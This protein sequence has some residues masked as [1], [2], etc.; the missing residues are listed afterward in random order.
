MPDLDLEH[1][2]LT[3]MT[4]QIAE[5][6]DKEIVN[7]LI[8]LQLVNTQ[9][10]TKS[11]VG[12]SWRDPNWADKTESWCKENCTGEHKLLNSNWYFEKARDATAFALKWS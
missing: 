2:I 1:E 8:A 7:D 9:G 10:W 11:N 12:K 4:K 3:E 5:E 6:I